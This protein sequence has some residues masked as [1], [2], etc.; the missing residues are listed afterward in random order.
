MVRDGPYVDV[1]R[2]GDDLPP[3]VRSR[4]ERQRAEI[5]RLI[6]EGHL[7]RA[8][9]LAHEHLAE[10]PHDDSLRSAIVTALD[11]SPDHRVRSRSRELA[12]K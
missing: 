1:Q 12:T 7:D 9:D 2:S 10:F 3:P 4:R 11:S 8:A 5:A 6:D